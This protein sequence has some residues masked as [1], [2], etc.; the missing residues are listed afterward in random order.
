MKRLISLIF[1]SFFI[2]TG[3]QK[4]S[5]TETPG[6]NP[7]SG[8]D[9]AKINQVL[10]NS[11]FIMKQIPELMAKADSYCTKNFSRLMKDDNVK[12]LSTNFIQS[13]ELQ[14]ELQK[15]LGDNETTTKFS[16]QF[17]RLYNKLQTDKTIL[18]L[19]QICK[20]DKEVYLF[21]Q[22]YGEP[23]LLVNLWKDNHFSDFFHDE[24]GSYSSFYYDGGAMIFMTN[25]QGKNSLMYSS[26]K[27]LPSYYWVIDSLDPDTLLV[28]QIEKCQMT[29]EYTN[30]QFWFNADKHTLK[31]DKQYQP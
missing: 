17:E 23:G 10:T 21:F 11:T 15:I 18:D 30:N 31:C 22:K 7:Y 1:L 6:R 9:F 4:V 20:K 14:A 27:D 8:T 3:C 19:E 16:L 13:S 2:F 29:F 12:K 28:T 5:T 26:G 24:N 25:A